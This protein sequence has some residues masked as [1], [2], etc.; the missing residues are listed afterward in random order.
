[1]EQD[2]TEGKWSPPWSSNQE[3]DDMY[4]LQAAGTGGTLSPESEDSDDLHFFKSLLP[5][6]RHLPRAKKTYIRLQ[7]QRIVFE[8]VYGGRKS[9][10]GDTAS[11]HQG[12]DSDGPMDMPCTV[13]IGAEMD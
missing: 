11:N 4:P 5:D 9:P 10:S 13:E 7:I 6:L 1:M 12:S 2:Q 3:S 8:E